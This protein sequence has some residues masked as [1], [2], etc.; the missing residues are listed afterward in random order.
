MNQKPIYLAPIQMKWLSVIRKT[1]GD[2]ALATQQH[3][4]IPSS[5]RED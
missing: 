3:F 4:G 1:G 2:A 5:G